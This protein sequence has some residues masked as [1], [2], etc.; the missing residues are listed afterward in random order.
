MTDSTQ[1]SDPNHGRGPAS[2]AGRSPADRPS[3]ART[4]AGSRPSG[5]VPRALEQLRRDPVLL[6]PF[7]VAG[8]VLAV[9]D[10]LRR[11]DPIPAL[12]SA[13]VG[14]RTVSI[15][16]TGYPTGTSHTTVPLESLLGLEPL[17][18]GWGLASY[19]LPLLAISIAGVLTISRAMDGEAS[20]GALGPFLGFVVAMDFGH[21]VLGSI[22]LF[23]TMGLLLGLPVL[24]LYF[25]LAIRL[26]AAPGRLVAGDSLRAAVGHSWRRTAGRG[27]SL[28]VAVLLFGLTAWLLASVPVVGT[29]ASTAV[30]APVHAATIVAFLQVADGRHR[31]S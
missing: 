13:R 8:V 27:G 29:I 30:V 7:A 17:Y 19:L 3:H 2:T 15:E 26:F 23:R 20:L 11:R 1:P 22:E 12:E 14:D 6:V 9:V 21:R 18:L 4:T 10:W 28:F 25:F 5:I 16:Y 31:S 24:A